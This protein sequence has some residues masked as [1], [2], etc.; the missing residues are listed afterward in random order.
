MKPLVPIFAGLVAVY[1]AA[2]CGPRVAPEER[3]VILVTLDTT[4]AD[5]LG[6]YGH[7][8]GLTPNLD[9]VGR[10]GVVFEEAIAQVP[11]TLPSHASLFTGRYPSAHGVRHNGIYRLRESETTLAEHLGSLGFET[12]GFAAAYVMNRGFGAEQGFAV[13]D[14]VPGNRYE[15]GQDRLYAAQRT[16]EAVNERA[17]RWLSQVPAGKRFFLWVHYYDPH[18]PYEPPESSGR[19]LRGEGYDREIS[20]MDS[21]FGD[22]LRALEADDRLDRSVLVVAGDHGESLGQHGEK[23]HGIFLYE[24]S[25]RVPLI[26]RAPGLL[27]SGKR[28]TGP[29][30]LVD[31]A[32]TVLDWIGASP[33]PAAQGRSL[34]PRIDGTEDGRG[35]LAHA[36]SLMPRL[37]FGWSELRMV[38]DGRFKYVDAPREELYDLREDP[39]EERDLASFDAER[40][41]EMGATLD[42][43]VRRTTDATAEAE[44]ARPLDPDEEARLRSLGYLGGDYFKSGGEGGR[45]DPKD[46]IAEIHRLDDARDLLAQGNAAGALAAVA[47]VLAANPK[48]HQARS[49]KVLALI[50]LGRLAEAEEEA[51]ASLAAAETDAEASAVLAEKAR[52]LL[53]SVLLLAGRSAE[54]EAQYRRLLRD[55]PTNG[56]AAVDLARLLIDLGR[57]EEA[58]ALIGDVLAREPANGMALAARFLVEW[59]AGRRD[60]AIATARALAE[61][62]AGDAP[63]LDRAGRLLLEEGDPARA[64]ACF[65]V[66]LEQSRTLDPGLLGRLGSARLASGDPK[67]AEAAFQAAASLAP[68]DPRPQH[69][70]GVLRLERGDEAGARAAFAKAS[71]ADPRFHASLLHL[72]RWLGRQG[73]REEA[74]RMLAEAEA[75]RPGDPEVSAARREIE[76]SVDR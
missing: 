52:G 61:A 53:A 76:G 5:R 27:P 34:R 23:T 55:D 65:E 21:C 33:L 18:D 2:S 3:S 62:R 30:E 17:I 66:A 63:V 29:V 50:E 74:L 32:P 60:D 46:G 6:I 72:G 56:S 51:L 35:A 11:L 20:Y 44:A 13:Y 9:R 67:G 12:A 45:T 24:P 70:L 41:Q 47:E 71:A 64:A 49:T 39:G 36:E 25:V 4:R 1:F 14:D 37:E 15:G 28:V 16:A 68:R 69:Y 42:A 75:R 19:A 59:K 58:T 54:A 38:R 48:N 22:L 7:G 10:E 31:V 43:W 40:A 26:L 73:R 57:E 8:G